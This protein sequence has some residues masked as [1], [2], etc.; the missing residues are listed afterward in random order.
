VDG[1]LSL[2]GRPGAQDLDEPR[3]AADVDEGGL[4]FWV[5]AHMGH[6]LAARIQYDT[7]PFF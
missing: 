7:L 1:E 5:L 6:E 3:G 2:L 4:L